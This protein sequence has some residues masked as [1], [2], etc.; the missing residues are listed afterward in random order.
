[1][2]SAVTFSDFVDAFRQY[3]RYDQF[4]YDGLKVLYD[5]LVEMEADT[6]YEI[7]LDVI[8]LCCDYSVETVEELAN[9]YDIDYDIEDNSYMNEDEI[10]TACQESMRQAVLDY[11]EYNTTVCGETP[12]GDIVYCSS[13]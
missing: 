11:L 7:D 9:M 4:G 1:M 2:K 6:G 8:G 12:S 3:D 10:S 5:Y 13:F